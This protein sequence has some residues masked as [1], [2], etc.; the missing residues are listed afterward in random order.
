MPS[1]FLTSGSSITISASGPLRSSRTG[2]A[3]AAGGAGGSGAGAGVD[4]GSPSAASRSG[5]RIAR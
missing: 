1:A 4:A 5:R 2:A 3:A